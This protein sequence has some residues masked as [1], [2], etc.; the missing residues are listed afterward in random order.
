MK[1]NSRTAAKPRRKTIALGRESTPVVWALA[2]HAPSPPFGDEGGG[3]TA[4]LEKNLPTLALARPANLLAE[5]KTR[6]FAT[7]KLPKQK[8]R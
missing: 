2:R 3:P 7:G 5:T 8:T 1:S 6:I 4:G